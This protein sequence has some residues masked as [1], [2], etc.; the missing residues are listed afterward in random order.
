MAYANQELEDPK[1]DIATATAL[2]DA[3]GITVNLKASG[4]ER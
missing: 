3:L 4:N 1:L 2:N